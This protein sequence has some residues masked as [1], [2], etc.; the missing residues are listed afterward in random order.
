[1]ALMGHLAPGIHCPPA[2][3]SGS[4]VSIERMAE[5]CRDSCLYI[6]D[7]QRG[8]GSR[9]E[10]IKID[11]TVCTFVRSQGN[12]KGRSTLT[13]DR[14]LR[15]S[16]DPAG[17][18]LTSAEELPPGVSVLGRIYIARV[19]PDEVREPALDIAQA[20]RIP[21]FITLLCLANALA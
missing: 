8:G 15:A 19:S 9:Q 18:A 11:E 2:A 1:M 5:F 21:L 7:Y 3:W 4:A 16:S 14:T 20:S 6:D 17:I 13:R 12:L 10:Q